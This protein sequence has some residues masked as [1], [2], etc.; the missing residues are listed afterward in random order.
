MTLKKS[1][2]PAKADKPK[3][4]VGQRRDRKMQVILCAAIL[5]LVVL[6]FY[7]KVIFGIANFWEDLIYQ[8]LPHRI[9]ARDSLSHFSFPFWNPYTFAGMPF[10]AAIHTGV[11]YPTNLLLSLL[12]LPMD[13]F[14][15][16]LELS[17]ILHVFIAGMTMF[18]FCNYRGLSH[19]SSL[20]AAISFMLCGFFVVHI[21]HSL[22]LY[23][24]AWLP[25]IMLFFLRGIE[26]KHPADF[27]YAAIVLGI[28]IFAG[29]PQITFY[30]FLFLV[31]FSAYCLFGVSKN[32]ISHGILFLAAFVIA[33]GI[34][35]IVLLP[36]MELSR[37]SARVNWTFQMASEGSMSFRQLLTFFIPKLFGGTTSD[38]PWRQELSF[39]LK[40][41]YHSGYWTFWETTFYTG[42]PAFIFGLVQFINVRRSV[43]ARFCLVWC[44]FSLFVAL[45]N[46]FPLYR[47]LF[48]YVPGFGTFRIPARILFTWNLLLPLLASHTMD[49]LKDA[50]NRRR[51]LLPLAIGGGISLLIFITVSSG[52]LENFWPEFGLEANKNYATKQSFYMGGVIL[53]SILATALLYASLLKH[54]LYKI[55]MLSILCID[56]FV[57]G[58]DYH[59]VQYSPSDYFSKNRPLAEFLS[60]ENS[61]TLFRTKMR[62]DGIM[63]LD[64]NQGMI[65]RIQLMEGYNPLNLYLKDLPTS[66]QARLD[67]FNVKYAIRLD[68][69][70]KSAGLVE[71][72]T[73]LPRAKM[74]YKA[75]IIPDDSS[76][77]AYLGSPDFHYTDEVVLPEK[78]TLALPGD[79]FPVANNLAI[80]T[81][82]NNQIG[83]SVRTEKNG[84]LWLSEIW[85]PAWKAIVDGK[86][87]KILRADYGFRAV[88]I[89]AGNH[90]VLF[91]YH[92][93]AFTVGAI[94][95]IFTAIGTVGTLLFFSRKGKRA[96][97]GVTAG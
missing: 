95:S 97:N 53:F 37:Q 87:T 43:Y 61:K 54:H 32:R 96:M 62:E 93:K 41:A 17:I 78:P 68:N 22:I 64:R 42:L 67:L 24:L 44:V 48:S 4:A 16:V 2:S 81:Y 40:D 30:E 27:I 21:I 25:L 90:R 59:I 73:F 19:L 66:E 91:V 35:M 56:L 26:K 51:Y 13:Q 80:T 45:G 50:E 14:W 15:Y 33:V 82:G 55:V 46:H 60:M 75:V 57:F 70:N 85:Y 77:K 94:I 12:P 7:N 63:L 29:H 83:L 89:A 69:A 38:N 31:A 34:A 79:T 11:F 8:E 1:L 74:F 72:P 36:S 71:N 49:E 39:W 47:L 20:F 76:T 65:D 6:V 84:I 3:T 23:I 10:F 18:L 5:F 88:E 86:E 9:F 92:S 28:S 58:M 52:F